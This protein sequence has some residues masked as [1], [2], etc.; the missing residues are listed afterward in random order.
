MQK[1]QKSQVFRDPVYGYITI[2]Y[3]IISKLIATPEFQRLRRIKQLAGVSMIYPG[4][5]HSRFSHSLGVYH[6]ATEIIQSTEVKEVLNER[7]QLLFLVS[8]LLHDIGH[9]PY[10]HAF[11]DVFKTNHEEIGAKIIS[12]SENITKILAEIDSEFASDVS[13]IISKK[14]KYIVIEQLISSQLDVDRLD[15]LVR[16]TYFTG[17]FYGF[18]DVDKIIR[19][20]RIRN[21]KIVF[22][23]SGLAAIESYLIS[24][25]HMYSQVYFHKKVRAYE[26]ILEKIYLRVSDLNK[27]GYFKEDE[28][29]VKF[30]KDPSNINNYLDIDD[31]YINKLIHRLQNT[32]DEILRTLVSD[33][34]NGK[35]WESTKYNKNKNFN[36][37]LENELEARYYSE[38]KTAQQTT[39]Q[40]LTK[41]VADHIYILRDEDKIVKLSRLSKLVNALSKTKTNELERYFF[42]PW[43]D[44]YM[45]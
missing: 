8:A 7:E 38:V 41:D 36:E 14:S 13:A 17:A 37:Q 23:E 45:L 27:E 5:D 12:E 35:V 15:Y 22:R 18:I 1:H 21:N 10:S 31:H 32:Q 4:A 3:E 28:L 19:S 34:I 9:G 30:I 43:K 40:E 20:I 25:H 2:N 26:L 16:D 39:Y 11:E 29:I 42:R 44:K 33:F 6:L 24:R